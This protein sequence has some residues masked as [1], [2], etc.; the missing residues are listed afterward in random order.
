MLYSNGVSSV[1]YSEGAAVCYILT[2]H[3]CV[4]F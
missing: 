2:D 3:Q 1:S 4:I